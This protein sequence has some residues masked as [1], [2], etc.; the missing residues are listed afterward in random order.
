METLRFVSEPPPKRQSTGWGWGWALAAIVLIASVARGWLLFSTPLVPGMNGGYYL[1]Q[2][3]SVLTKGTLGVPDLPL[4]F[5]VQ[6]ALARVIEFVSHRGLEP[7]VL[8]A[9]K[10]ADA[11]L[12]A[13]IAVPVFLLV[14]RWGKAANAPGWI[15]LAAAA[16]AALSAPALSMVG[17]FE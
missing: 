14:R 6:A 16:I 9:V 1:V 12:P 4:T 11:V 10:L 17:D 3:R 15:A 13:L 2:A 7:S 5:Y 8:L